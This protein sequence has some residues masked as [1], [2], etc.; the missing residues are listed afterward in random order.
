M[1]SASSTHE[2]GDQEAHAWGNPERWGGEG[3]EG[4]SGWGHCAPVADSCRYMV[5][6]S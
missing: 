1:T 6:P 2:A 3:L 5:K 4:G